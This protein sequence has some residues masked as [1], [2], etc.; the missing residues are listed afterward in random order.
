MDNVYLEKLNS[1][2]IG[3]GSLSIQNCYFTQL[4]NTGIDIQ[5]GPV[6]IHHSVLESKEDLGN[7]GILF[8][9]THHI[10]QLSDVRI[11]RFHVGVVCHGTSIFQS[12]SILHCGAIGICID[13]PSD[14]F[15]CEIENCEID[16]CSRGISANNCLLSVLT[17]HVRHSKCAIYATSSM[18]VR[19]ENCC[20]HDCKES[21]LKC[22]NVQSLQSSSNS[23]YDSKIGY[24]LDNVLYVG[25]VHNHFMYV[26]NTVFSLAGSI[27]P[28]SRANHQ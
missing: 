14:P 26:S 9:S 2:V 23:L 20:L 21:I 19:I 22:Q 28:T 6:A 4:F 3:S 25:M 27:V 16:L 12:C 5:E 18:T 17:S 24:D 15:L 10:Q 11:Q 13:N 1:V 7:A 8:E